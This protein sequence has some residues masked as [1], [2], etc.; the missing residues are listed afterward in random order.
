[1]DEPDAQ[2][3]GPRDR[4]TDALGDLSVLP[5]ETVC[6]ILEY[7]TPRDVARFACVSRFFFFFFSFL[8]C[9]FNY[10]NCN[11]NSQ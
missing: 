4:R 6:A 3:L 5:D 10:H 7:L 2:S 11:F 1:M 8:Y 9:F